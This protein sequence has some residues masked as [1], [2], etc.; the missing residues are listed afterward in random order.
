MQT[1]VLLTSS[2]GLKSITSTVSPASK[3]SLSCGITQKPSAF[4]M[5]IAAPAP[6]ASG[7]Q[8]Y[9]PPTRPTLT[10]TYSLCLSEDTRRLESTASILRSC[11]SL[12]PVKDLRTGYTK[13]STARYAD[14]G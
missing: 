7:A 11:D 2:A 9:R 13:L 3:P 5:L 6:L 4:T 10:L 12:S 8:T 1:M 14:T